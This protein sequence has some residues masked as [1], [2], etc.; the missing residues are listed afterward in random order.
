MDVEE[1][2]KEAEVFQS[3]FA[4]L[5]RLLTSSHEA[6]L[7]FAA[8]LFAKGLVPQGIINEVQVPGAKGVMAML[9]SLM[10]KVQNE[11]EAFYKFLTALEADSYFMD[12]AAKMRRES[13]GEAQRHTVETDGG[14]SNGIGELGWAFSVLLGDIT[15]MCQT[16]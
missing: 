1:K 14:R 5:Q 11:P 9:S 12:I 16:Y 15:S 10:G 4:V 8:E 6:C 7:N 13:K 2:A 3:H